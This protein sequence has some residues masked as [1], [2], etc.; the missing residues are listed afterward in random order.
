M[1]LVTHNLRE[2][3]EYSSGTPIQENRQWRKNAARFRQL[4]ELAR[5]LPRSSQD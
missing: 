1:S 5:R 3:G 4:D 2:P